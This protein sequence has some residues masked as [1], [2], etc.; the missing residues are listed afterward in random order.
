MAAAD[1]DAGMIGRQQR[2]RDA[3]VL[4]AAEQVLGVEQAEGEADQRRARR[5]RDVALLPG[6]ADAHH[7]LAV[8]PA[9][10]DVADVAH[11]RGVRARGRTGQREAGDIEALGEAR[12]V[13]LLLLGRAVLLDQLARPQRVRHHDDDAGVRRA[14]ADA[15]QHQRLRLRRE[16]EAAVLLGDEHAEEAVLLDETPDLGRDLAVVVADLPVVEHPAELVAGP[17]EER[18]LL[19]GQ[20]DGRNGAQLLPVG[21]AGEQLGIEADG[22]G[23]ERLLLGRGD[24]GQDALDLVEDRPGERGT[25]DGGHRQPREHD[26]RQPGEHAEGTD[27]HVVFPVQHART[28][29]RR[30]RPPGPGPR[31]TRAPAAWQARRHPQ[32]KWL[33]ARVPPWCAAPPMG[34]PRALHQIRKFKA[35]TLSKVDV[36][37]NLRPTH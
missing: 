18:L 25:P 1:L 30:W 36:Y 23:V 27:L 3:D 11:G 6:G 7:L 37:V 16:A 15:S 14:R 24:L 4:A 28:A 5:Q 10:G 2:H 8:V 35:L 33:R 17:V 34:A 32:C 19:L 12:E 20:R 31:P 21:R 22:A 26:H 29:R 9:L 13:V